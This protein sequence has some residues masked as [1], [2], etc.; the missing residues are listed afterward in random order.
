MSTSEVAKSIFG[1]NVMC[2]EVSGCLGE[3]LDGVLQVDASRYFYYR[4]TI[5]SDLAI[6]KGAL[7]VHHVLVGGREVPKSGGIPRVDVSTP[8][9]H[10]T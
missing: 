9:E 8:F 7:E 10:S 2:V 5:D 1:A 4:L 6:F 3:L